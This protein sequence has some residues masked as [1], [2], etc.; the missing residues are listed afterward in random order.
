M[1]KVA[2]KIMFLENLRVFGFQCGAVC[3]YWD[4]EA[5]R[6][7]KPTDDAFHSRTGT[8]PPTAR[9]TASGSRNYPVLVVHL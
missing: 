9:R 2:I 5:C 3:S 4:H 6:Q 8:S 7:H 1:H